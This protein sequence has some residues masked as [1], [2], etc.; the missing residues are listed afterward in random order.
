V[1]VR[2]GDDP[3]E[4]AD[5]DGGEG[6]LARY[7]AANSRSGPMHAKPSDAERRLAQAALVPGLRGYW[8]MRSLLMPKG[9]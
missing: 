4:G 5:A 9:V 8:E 6:T 2:P 7:I 1:A 3:G